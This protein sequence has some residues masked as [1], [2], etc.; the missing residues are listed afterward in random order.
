MSVN[1]FVDLLHLRV[2][3]LFL[4]L[5]GFSAIRGNIFPNQLA[6][7]EVCCK[8]FLYYAINFT[9]AIPIHIA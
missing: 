5:F 1:K 8:N 9:V 4:R 2:F 6:Y 7:C 3:V